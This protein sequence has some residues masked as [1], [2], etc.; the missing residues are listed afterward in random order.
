MRKPA[1][2]EDPLLFPVILHVLLGMFQNRGTPKAGGFPFVP[3]LNQGEVGTELQL[4][5]PTLGHPVKHH[6]PDRAPQRS[7]RRVQHCRRINRKHCP[8]TGVPRQ[9]ICHLRQGKLPH[10][11]LTA[12]AHESPW[13]WMSSLGKC[14]LITLFLLS[15]FLFCD[16]AVGRWYACRQVHDGTTVKKWTALLVSQ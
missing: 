6:V 5:T 9:G 12:G 10:T 15:I 2:F 1:D 3:P 16:P 8:A 11:R 14:M 7:A 13:N 4:S